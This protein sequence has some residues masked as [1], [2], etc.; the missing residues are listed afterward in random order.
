MWPNSLA[1]TSRS[2]FMPA[3]AF[4]RVSLHARRRLLLPY[5]LAPFCSL[6][7]L[8]PSTLARW[9]FFLPPPLLAGASSLFHP[10]SLALPPCFFLAHRH[11]LSSIYLA[12]DSSR[13]PIV[14]IVG[15]FVLVIGT[16]ALVVGSFALVVGPSAFAGTPFFLLFLLLAR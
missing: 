11:S 6:A 5:A 7:L 2:P 1:P 13:L 4:F 16:F 15:P 3:G 12:R 14:L 8:P 9:R 10:G